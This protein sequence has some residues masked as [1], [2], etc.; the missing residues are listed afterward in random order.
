M[1]ARVKYYQLQQLAIQNDTDVRTESAIQQGNEQ[2]QPQ[3][4]QGGSSSSG[5]VRDLAGGVLRGAG[6][7]ARGV[8]GFFEGCC[9]R[10]YTIWRS[11]RKSS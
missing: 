8:G 9:N 5:V 6:Q 1:K 10:F 3:V 11:I 2:P 7:V 4:Q